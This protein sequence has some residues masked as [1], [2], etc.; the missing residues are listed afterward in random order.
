M[1]SLKL[2]DNYTYECQQ[3]EDEVHVYVREVTD[4]K[5]ALVRLRIGN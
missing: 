1:E 2:T 5:S 4:E 3:R